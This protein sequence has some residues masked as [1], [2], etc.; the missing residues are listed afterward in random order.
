[1]NRSTPGLPVHHQGAPKTMQNWLLEN[2]L[3]ILEKVKDLDEK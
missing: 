2:D 1:M 3:T